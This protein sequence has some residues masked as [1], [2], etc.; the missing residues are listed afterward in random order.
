MMK[1]ENEQHTE[2]KP[3]LKERTS[4]ITRLTRFYFIAGII[5]LV[6]AFFDSPQFAVYVGIFWLFFGVGLALISYGTDHKG[7]R[8][9]GPLKVIGWVM[10]VLTV[11][12]ISARNNPALGG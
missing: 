3:S 7:K 11:L 12:T 1:Q 9:A 8:M 4:F 6:I 2:G 10:I 5:G